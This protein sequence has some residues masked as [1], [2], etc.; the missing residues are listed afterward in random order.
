ML[1]PCSGSLL[2][3]AGLHICPLLSQWKVVPLPSTCASFTEKCADAL[4]WILYIETLGLRRILILCIKIEKQPTIN[5]VSST[6]RGCIYFDNRKNGAGLWRGR[7]ISI[8][9]QGKAR[10]RY[11][12]TLYTVSSFW[13]VRSCLSE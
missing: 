10:L 2:C 12:H 4:K 5:Q 7:T 13:L 1:S 3:E 8:S 9:W 6:Q 11:G